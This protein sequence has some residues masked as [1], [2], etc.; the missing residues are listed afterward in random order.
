MV[1]LRYSSASYSQVFDHGARGA[2]LTRKST[3]TKKQLAY[4]SPAS[5]PP[6]VSHSSMVY[7]CAWL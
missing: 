1:V 7:V 4:L 5:P 6:T 2:I 3:S